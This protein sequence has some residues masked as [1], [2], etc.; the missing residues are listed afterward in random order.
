M[1]TNKYILLHIVSLFRLISFISSIWNKSGKMI[2]PVKWFISPIIEICYKCWKSYHPRPFIIGLSLTGIWNTV[3]K[4]THWGLVTPYGVIDL[5]QHCL[6]WW[7]GAVRHQTITWTNV[8]SISL[9]PIPEWFHRKCKRYAGKTYHSKS[10]FQRF[11]CTCLSTMTL[12]VILWIPI[13]LV[14]V[15]CCPNYLSSACNMSDISLPWDQW[16]S[17]YSNWTL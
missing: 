1:A 10:I 8:D 11:L 16:V 7:F 12:S 9:P 5:H 3:Y 15:K 2:S 14:C 17:E 13:E 6:R 4:L